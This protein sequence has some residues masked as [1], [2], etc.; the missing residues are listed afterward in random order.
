[1]K[2]NGTTVPEAAQEKDTPANED[3]KMITTEIIHTVDK[4]CIQANE[5]IASMNP[6]AG[7]VVT[8][9][10]HIAAM[11][12]IATAITVQVTEETIMIMTTAAIHAVDKVRIANTGDSRPWIRKKGV[13]G[14]AG[15]ALYRMTGA[16]T[17]KESNIMVQEE[18]M[19]EIEMEDTV[20]ASKA[21]E[22]T[23]QEMATTT[24]NM[25]TVVSEAV[26]MK[27]MKA[28]AIMVADKGHAPAMKKMRTVIIKAKIMVKIMK[29]EEFRVQSKVRA[30]NN[31]H[32]GPILKV[33]PVVY[34]VLK[35][36]AAA[37]VLLPWIK[38]S[39][40]EL[41]VKEG[42]WRT[43]PEMHMNLLPKKQEQLPEEEGKERRRDKRFF[44]LRKQSPKNFKILEAFNIYKPIVNSKLSGSR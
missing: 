40:E 2:I 24:M 23:V 13:K 30:K 22:D 29:G 35:E 34:K 31:N 3:R 10:I 33:L 37:E 44:H 25:R 5:V 14:H 12:R 38:K 8:D 39:S 28:M 9:K 26:A 6:R 43:N 19:K 18:K 32:A 41:P 16:I 42:E 15:K 11:I 1:M 27:T 17:R 7:K 4:V 20:P 21:E 36:P